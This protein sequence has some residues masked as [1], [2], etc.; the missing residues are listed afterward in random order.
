MINNYLKVMGLKYLVVIVLKLIA[1]M[2]I[3]I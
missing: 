1:M 2:V 3:L